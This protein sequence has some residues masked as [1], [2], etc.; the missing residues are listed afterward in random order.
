MADNSI[1]VTVLSG[2]LGASKTTVLDHLLRESASRNLAAL[3][4]DMGSVNVDAELEGDWTTFD[5]RFPTFEPP[6]LEGGSDGD[7]KTEIDGKHDRTAEL[8]IAD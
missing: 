5:D 8:G 6:E 3:V 7:G 4:N 2:I 1:P